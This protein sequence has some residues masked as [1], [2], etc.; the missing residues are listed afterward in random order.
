MAGPDDL[1]QRRGLETDVY[2]PAEDSALLASATVEAV[3]P[4]DTVLE[5]GTGSGWVAAQVREI[6][7]ARVIAADV[8]PHACRQAHDRGLEVVRADLVSPFR[9]DSFDVV[10]FNPPYLPTDPDNEWDDWMEAAL[11]GGETGRRLVEPFLERVGRVL[12]PGGCVLLLVSS[13]T[14]REAVESIAADAGFDAEAVREESYPF[15]TLWVL[16]VV[17]AG[18]DPS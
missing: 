4:S 3:E 8:N 10:A 11:S 7:E 13:L 18:P 17:P 5:V 9:D 2:Q 15:E 14:D 16:R 12:A 1:A 6:R